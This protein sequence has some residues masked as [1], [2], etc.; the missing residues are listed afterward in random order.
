MTARPRRVGYLCRDLQVRTD[1]AFGDQ[2][3]KKK[4]KKKTDRETESRPSGHGDLDPIKTA[5]NRHPSPLEGSKRAQE[6]RPI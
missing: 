1:T 3:I 6:W 2:S 4:Q 5:A